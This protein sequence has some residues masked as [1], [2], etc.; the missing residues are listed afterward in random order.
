ME[1]SIR[2]DL[3]SRLLMTPLGMGKGFSRVRIAG[4][5]V[6]VC[7]GWGFRAKF[8]RAAVSAV[9]RAPKVWIT[10]GAHGWRGR[11]LVNGAG[12]GL[13]ELTLQPTQRA[14]VLGFP[15]R[16]GHLI[17]SLDD[18]DGLMEALAVQ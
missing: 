3:F 11:W 2:F 1:F 4:D 10:R 17:V 13:V 15:V 5:T 8:P 6:H 14:R 16:L 7:M 9:A 18:P 12:D